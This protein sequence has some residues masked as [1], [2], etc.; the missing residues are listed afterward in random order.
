MDW[1]SDRLGSAVKGENPT[2]IH[3]LKSGFAVL[4]DTQFLPGYCILLAY[5]KAKSLNDLGPVPRLL[6]LREMSILGDAILEVCKPLRINYEILGNADD[7]FLHAHVIPRYAWED[8]DFR[9]QPVWLYPAE[10]RTSPEF[11]FS[12]EKHGEL[13]RNLAE[14][15]KELTAK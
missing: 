14:K 5:P 1:K 2:V 9:K 10:Y 6:F 4:G 11:Q 3:R 13:K 15:L 8:D 7:A 12:E